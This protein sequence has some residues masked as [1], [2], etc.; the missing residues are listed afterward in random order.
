MDGSDRGHDSIGN[1]IA[2]QRKLRG[3]SVED[4]AH[5]TRIPLRSLMLLEEGAFDDEVDGFVRGFVR[6]VAEAL[7]LDPEETLARTLR[8]P[9]ADGAGQESRQQLS[10]GRVFITVAAILGVGAVGV[11][12]QNLSVSRQIS[13]PA[14]AEV[15]L[16]RRDPV[17]E[18]AEAQSVAG[19]PAL[20]VR[21]LIDAPGAVGLGAD[22]ERSEFVG[23]LGPPDSR[24][25]G[26][27]D[28]R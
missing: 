26:N 21:V 12:V 13:S 17:R 15:S 14:P 2:G 19:L 20:P 7:G 9:G 11:L 18:L 4:V 22:A 25:Q 6:T 5:Q 3:L 1:Y 27:R 16:I 8:E 10:L 28:A 24:S 23:S